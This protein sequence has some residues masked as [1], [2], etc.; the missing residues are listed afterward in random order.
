[1][2]AASILRLPLPSNPVLSGS[3][4]SPANLRPSIPSLSSQATACI[5]CQEA[6]PILAALTNKPCFKKLQGTW[7][8]LLLPFSCLHS[9]FCTVSPK[10]SV[11]H[12]LDF[13]TIRLC[14][15]PWNLPWFY[16]PGPVLQNWGK[17]QNW[18]KPG[19]MLQYHRMMR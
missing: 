11:H 5:S 15:K 6:E 3:S 1:M 8:R 19:I 14:V 4:T 16:S 2:S 7:L 12:L 9:S 10:I 17:R 18:H 13:I